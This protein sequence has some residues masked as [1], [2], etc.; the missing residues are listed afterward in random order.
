MYDFNLFFQSRALISRS[1]AA[2]V[3]LAYPA[4]GVRLLSDLRLRRGLHVCSKFSGGYR[5]N[6]I[7][8]T[9]TWNIEKSKVKLVECGIYLESE[10][11][12]GAVV[13]PAVMVEDW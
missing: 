5:N 6:Q 10:P 3:G 4:V 13:L 1:E 11:R 8:L 7:K 12:W 2:A 9:M